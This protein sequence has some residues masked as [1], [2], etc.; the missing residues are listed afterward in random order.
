MNL[1]INY[2]IPNF[3]ITPKQQNVVNPQ[4]KATVNTK[5]LKPIAVTASLALASITSNNILQ[6]SRSDNELKTKE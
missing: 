2:Y 6:Q 4:F 5:Q 1:S 3:K